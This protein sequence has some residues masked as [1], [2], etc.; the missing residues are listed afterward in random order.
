MAAIRAFYN[1]ATPRATEA[2][3]YCGEFPLHELPPDAAT[4]FKLMLGLAQAAI[5][6]EIHGQARAPGTPWPNTIVLE[7][8]T[9]PFG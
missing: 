2:L 8:G 6:V 9:A 5:A 1:A 7:R 3:E 4:L